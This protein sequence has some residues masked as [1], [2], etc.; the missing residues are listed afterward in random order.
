MDQRSEDGAAASNLQIA[1][2]QDHALQT[3]FV[4]G[5]LARA[6]LAELEPD[7]VSANVAT[8]LVQIIDAATAGRE[9]LGQAVFALGHAEV[10]QNGVVQALQTL[11]RQFQERTGIETAVLVTGAT[12]NLSNEAAETLHHAAAE[13]L[14][15]IERHSQA[16]AV[17]LSLQLARRSVT[18]SIHDDGV[19]I[20]NPALERIASSANQFGLRGVGLRVRRLGGTFI[21]R[22]SRDGGFVVRTR[23]PLAP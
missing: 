18:L 21:A 11:A 17:V 3:F 7:Q 6:A 5:L 2:L 9:H 14:A 23:L 22:P 4:I 12:R 8:A 13:A 1:A 20:A 15:N 16:G 19:G 10:G